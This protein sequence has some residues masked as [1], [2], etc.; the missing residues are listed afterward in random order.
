MRPASQSAA[1][2]AAT[3]QCVVETISFVKETQ[4]NY[5]FWLR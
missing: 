3:V 2:A 5:F 4:A 1:A